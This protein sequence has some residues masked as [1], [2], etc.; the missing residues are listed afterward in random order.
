MRIRPGAHRNFVARRIGDCRSPISQRIPAAEEENQQL[1]GLEK[2]RARFVR[3]AMDDREF[4]TPA[5]FIVAARKFESV[6]QQRRDRVGVP[7]HVKHRHAASRQGTKTIDRI[8]ASKRGAQLS[9]GHSLGGLQMTVPQARPAGKV[10]D[11]ENS[12]DAADFIN[13]IFRLVVEHQA[14]AAL[15]Q[16]AGRGRQGIFPDHDFVKFRINL[17]P[18]L[19][20]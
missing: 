8:D 11:R 1:L 20:P 7:V 13:I 14:A 5:S 4:G 19:V 2:F 15:P 6:L 17:A 10:R 18:L 16:Q 3:L 9:L 12:G